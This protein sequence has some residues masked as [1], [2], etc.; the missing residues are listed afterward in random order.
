M[1]P[2]VAVWS[3]PDAGRATAASTRLQHVGIS[4][5]PLQS[6]PNLRDRVW[7]FVAPDRSAA[8]RREIETLPFPLL[9]DSVP[10]PDVREDDIP[11]HAA[12]LTG[13]YRN[14]SIAWAMLLFCPVGFFVLPF[15][16]WL[17][18]ALMS[19]AASAVVMKR[20]LTCPSCRRSLLTV[21]VDGSRRRC[22]H[23]GLTFWVAE[24]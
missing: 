11:G 22:S 8:A 5:T 18:A 24:A 7:L 14:E 6:H 15:P 3:F 4:S 16:W 10:L 20:V 13:R 1:T 17:L 9:N 19:G 2:Q 23:C 21:D 12:S